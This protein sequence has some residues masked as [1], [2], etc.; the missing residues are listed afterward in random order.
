MILRGALW[1]DRLLDLDLVFFV[2]NSVVLIDDCTLL[3]GL[4]RIEHESSSAILSRARARATRIRRSRTQS[5]RRCTIGTDIRRAGRGNRGLGSLDV[6]LEAVGLLVLNLVCVSAQTRSLLNLL[7]ELYPDL[8][9]QL[10]IVLWTNFRRFLKMGVEVEKVEYGFNNLSSASGPLFIILDETLHDILII[11]TFGN[12]GS[13]FSARE[14]H[15]SSNLLERS[16]GFVQIDHHIIS[17]CTDFCAEPRR[18]EE[19]DEG[20]VWVKGS[21]VKT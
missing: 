7:I 8:N 5:G 4:V 18:L 2:L 11:C 15:S 13:K 17:H 20:F 21:E 16:E 1:L 3:P 14:G 9:E 10:D 19:L 6:R 12:Q